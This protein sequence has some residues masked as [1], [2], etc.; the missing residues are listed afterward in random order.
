M[1]RFLNKQ[2]HVKF[3]GGREATGVLKGYDPLVNLVLDE[4]IEFIRENPYHLT[5]ETRKLGLVICRGTSISLLSPQEGFHA[6]PNPF[7][8]PEG[9]QESYSQTGQ[10]D[11]CSL[12]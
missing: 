5:D 4:A 3:F 2:V 6:I 9:F 11:G 8:L 12:T 7:P 10:T 1:S